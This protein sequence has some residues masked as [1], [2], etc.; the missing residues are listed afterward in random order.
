MK[1][2]VVYHTHTSCEYTVM[3]GKR[4]NDDMYRMYTASTAVFYLQRKSFVSLWLHTAR[5]D[6]VYQ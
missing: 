4:M 3:F 2:A 5:A 1:T 6:Y